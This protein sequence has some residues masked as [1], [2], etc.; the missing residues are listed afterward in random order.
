MESHSQF[1]RRSPNRLFL[2][3]LAMPLAGLV[4]LE[5]WSRQVS[6]PRRIGPTPACEAAGSG[7]YQEQR[8]LAEQLAQAHARGIEPS[9]DQ[10]LQAVVEVERSQIG[11]A[12]GLYC[13]GVAFVANDMPAEAEM[14][15]RR[16][17]VE[18]AFQDILSRHPENPEF[19]ANVAAGRQYPL[20]LV[21]TTAHTIFR[22]RDLL[23]LS[24]GCYVARLWTSFKVYFLPW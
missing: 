7:A 10:L 22:S 4:S 21:A 23:D 20:G 15:V 8:A 1:P 16:H 19:S 6:C 5:A 24:F 11:G 18:H 13:S 2:L 17:E 9:E 3:L 14:F 12:N